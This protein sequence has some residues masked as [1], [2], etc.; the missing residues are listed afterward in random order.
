MASMISLEKVLRVTESV[1]DGGRASL[2][3]R[4]CTH[5]PLRLGHNGDGNLELE[6]H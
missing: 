2:M 1:L 3:W 4:N 6:R 5:S